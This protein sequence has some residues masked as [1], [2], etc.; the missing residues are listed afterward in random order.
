MEEKDVENNG[1]T[2][3]ESKVKVALIQGVWIILELVQYL[4]V[5]TQSQQD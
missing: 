4:Q 1:K 2:I 3:A 5:P